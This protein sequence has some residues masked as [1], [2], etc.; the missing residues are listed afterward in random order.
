MVINLIAAGCVRDPRPSS[1]RWEVAMVAG[2]AVRGTVA[3]GFEA[4]RDQVAAVAA[5]EP[6]LGAQLAAYRHGELVVDLWAGPELDGD[7]LLG[8]YS[9]SKGAAHLVGALLVQDGGQGSPRPARA[10]GPPGRPGGGGHRFRAGRA[11]R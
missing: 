2:E 1:E 4:V 8:V 6:G 11:G 3:D 7:S 9:A 5:S 10:A